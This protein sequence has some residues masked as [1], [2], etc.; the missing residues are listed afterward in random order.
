MTFDA[1]LLRLEAV[2]N[3]SNG[4]SSPARDEKEK[5][6]VYGSNGLIGYTAEANSSKNTIVIGRVGSYCGSVH[7]SKNSCWVTD[8][9]IK[10]TVKD[11]NDPF[12]LYYVLKHLNLNNWRSG[13]GQP[14]L[15]QAT[16]NAIEALIPPASAQRL[17]SKFLLAMDDRI[18]LLRE[19]NEILE[20]IAHSLFKSWFVDFD[21]V[22][23]KK[24]GRKPEVMDEA[25][26]ELFPNSFEQSEFGEIPKGW[27]QGKLADLA[28]F[29][30]GYAFKGKDWTES[31]HP[32]IKIGNVKPRLIS[33]DGCSFVS[34]QTVNGLDRF[35]LHRGDLLV[36]MTGYVGETG[37]VPQ[38]SPSAYLNQRVG[39]FSTK[40]GSSNIGFVY[41][42]ARSKEFKNFAENQA[43]G[44]AQANVSGDDLLKFPTV[45]PDAKILSIFNLITFP[46][47]DAIISNYEKEQTLLDLR[48]TLLPRLISGQLRLPDA[49][50]Q[51][52]AATA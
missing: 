29:Q 3:F 34:Q 6:S 22:R 51:I 8:N 27:Q 45:I 25:T 49:E 39:R 46:L 35:K 21:P 42:L 5:I 23:A 4:R 26:A 2:L 24:E 37:L 50:E 1:Q 7:F 19:T 12:F 47:I 28:S 10:A 33:F 16:L 14:L 36:G 38:V 31:G 9:A 18:T 40:T 44:S 15:N 17:I 30:N 32:V 13:S 11:D 52:E 41:C 48:D 20:T 43:H